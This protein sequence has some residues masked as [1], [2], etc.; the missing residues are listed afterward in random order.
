MSESL[1]CVELREE[2]T[3]L[4]EAGGAEVGWFKTGI[5]SAHLS[6]NPPYQSVTSKPPS[7]NQR[8][9]R[10]RLCETFTV[11]LMWAVGAS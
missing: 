10:I 1:N 4:E 8:V 6:Q 3:E 7:F 11:A 9:S 5:V 2:Q